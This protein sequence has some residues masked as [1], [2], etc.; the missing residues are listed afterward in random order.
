MIDNFKTKLIQAYRLGRSHARY[1]EIPSYRVIF[2]D[3]A[4]IYEEVFRTYE[5]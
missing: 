1:P 4:S 3:T 2:K 5:G